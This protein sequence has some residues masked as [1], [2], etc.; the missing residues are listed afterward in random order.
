M[1]LNC[2]VD[3]NNSS[4]KINQVQWKKVRGDV[5]VV[6]FE[7]GKV[8][9]DSTD[10]SY[11]GRVQ[12]FSSEE[13]SKGNFSLRL[14]NIRAEDRGAYSCEVY[15]G[16]FSNSTTVELQPTGGFRNYI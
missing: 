16:E 1:T 8:Q 12:L 2:S 6:L 7:D 9:T 15:S 10:E 4:E 11:R 3:S 13:T 14:K 5:L